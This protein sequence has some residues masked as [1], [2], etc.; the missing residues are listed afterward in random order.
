[1]PEPEAG[2]AARLRGQDSTRNHALGPASAAEW[3]E[4]IASLPATGVNTPPGDDILA[5]L[6]AHL[7]DELVED[8]AEGVVAMLLSQA[9]AEPDDEDDASSDLRQI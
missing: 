8:M 7:M 9:A 2:T 3:Q 1:M 6:P 4:D 5:G